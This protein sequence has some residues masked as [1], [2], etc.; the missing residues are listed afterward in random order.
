MLKL[1]FFI[2]NNLFCSQNKFTESE[3]IL[4]E[5]SSYLFNLASDYFYSKKYDD[6]YAYFIKLAEKKELSKDEKAISLFNAAL[7]LERQKKH[8][9]ANLLFTKI[10]DDFSFSFLHKDSF[11]RLA[12]NC[13]EIDD[14]T[15]IIKNLNRWKRSDVKLSLAHDFEFMVRVGLSYFKL[16]SLFESTKYLN[17]SIS[18]YKNKYASL[19][20][21]AE[22]LKMTKDAINELTLIAFE[23]LG[24]SYIKNGS[25]IDLSFP[26][27]T[28]QDKIKQRLENA[29]ELKAFYYIKAQDVYLDM[30]KAGDRYIASKALFDIGNMYKNI[31]EEL[32]NSEIPPNIKHYKLEKNYKNELS[33][34]LE[35]IKKKAIIAF[36]KNIEYA[37]VFE[38]S[39]SW[40]ERS[41]SLKNILNNL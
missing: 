6:S 3:L 5:K 8:L 35:P 32:L 29:L 18:V 16:D 33:I 34:I 24:A 31:Y 14:Q 12:A 21:N 26:L 11:Y 22:S 9:D 4:L 23:T 17:S 7:S 27:N 37:K 38:Y 41:V 25:K 13:H 15:C 20:K 39:N 2:L 1:V 36:D 30:I 10:V 19:I 28:K 40:I